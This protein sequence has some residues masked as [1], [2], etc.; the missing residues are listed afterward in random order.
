MTTQGQ[1]RRRGLQPRR[2]HRRARAESLAAADPAGR[3]TLRSSSSTTARP[4]RHRPALQQLRRVPRAMRVIH[5]PNSGW[6]GR[7]RNRRRRTPPPASTSFRDHDDELSRGP[8]PALR[9]RAR[10]GRRHRLRQGGADRPARASCPLARRTIAVADP[11][12]DDLAVS[13]TV[14]KLSAATGCWSTG[15][16][17]LRAGSG[18]RTTTSWLR[19]SL[20]LMS[21]RCWPTTRLQVD[22]SHGRHNNS[23]GKVYP[24]GLLGL[25]RR[26]P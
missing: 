24:E 2:Q 19:R 8:R 21:Y 11:I 4:T 3:A 14:H 13:R 18:W 26:G 7:P 12:S 15:S 25:L 6:P 9:D 22:P 1:R 23:S 20:A 17:S 10:A 5:I 16:A